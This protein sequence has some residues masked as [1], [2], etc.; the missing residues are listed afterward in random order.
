ML[1]G[2]SSLDLMGGFPDISDTN[3]CEG[4]KKELENL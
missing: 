1:D 2:S 3:V 4:I